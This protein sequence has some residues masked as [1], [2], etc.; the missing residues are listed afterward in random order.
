[1]KKVIIFLVINLIIGNTVAWFLGAAPIEFPVIEY[2]KAEENRIAELK[3]EIEKSQDV[4]AL[5]ALGAI[6]SSHNEL[7]KANNYLQQALNIDPNSP[8][9]IAVYNSNETKRSGAMLDLGMGIYKLYWLWQACDGL[10][11]AVSLSPDN[12]EV[13]IY[14][15]ATFAGIGKVNRYFDEVFND[16]AWFL[17]FISKYKSNIPVELEQQFYLSM[18]TVYLE[19]KDEDSIGLAKN[20]LARLEKNGEMSLMQQ[21]DLKKLKQKLSEIG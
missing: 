8:L 1:M 11:Q 13:R 5:V 20:Y 17:D 4:D 9:T 21:N 16:E 6:Y 18:A 7:E 3:R 14:R 19:S 2:S 10:N 15:L 12:F